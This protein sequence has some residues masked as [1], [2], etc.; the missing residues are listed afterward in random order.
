MGMCDHISCALVSAGANVVK[1]YPFGPYDETLPYIMRRA[2][3]NKGF[4]A[5][6]IRERSLLLKEIR[7]RTI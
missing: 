6:T 2:N 5:R 1:Y 7:R 3:E 4:V